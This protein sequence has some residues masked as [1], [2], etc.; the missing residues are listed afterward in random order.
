[1]VE[2]TKS[3]VVRITDQSTNGTAYDEGMLRKN[4]SAETTERPYVLDFGGNVTVAVCFT[5]GEEKSFVASGGSAQT[6]SPQAVDSS[7]Q[8]GRGSRRTT[9]WLR[10]VRSDDVEK[11]S[12]SSSKGALGGMYRELSRR[13]R[14]AMTLVALGIVAVLFVVGSLLVSGLRW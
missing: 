11:N 1:L 2:I 7:A 6:F 10:D 5:E 12:V 9:T 4:E 14:L 13:G 8:A 3:G